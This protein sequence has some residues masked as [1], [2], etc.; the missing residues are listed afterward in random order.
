MRATAWSLFAG[1]LCA[2]L[3]AQMSGTYVIDAA[4]SGTSFRSFTE[5]VNALFVNGVSGACDMLVMP[6]TYTESV[7]I[8]PI[9]GASPQNRILFRAAQGPGTVSLAGGA[10]DTIAMVGVAFL[11][12]QS[13]IFDGIDFTGASGHAISATT[14]CEDIEIRDCT[15]TGNHRSNAPGEWRHALIVSE[16]SG[17]E[18][19]WR[20]HHNRMQIPARTNRGT[21]GIYLSNGGGW[22]FSDNEV[23]LNGCDYGLWLINN[24]RRLDTVWNNLF[25]GSLATAGGTYANNVC[26][27]RADISNYENDFVHN[28]FVVNI[29]GNGCCIATGGY[30]SGTQTVQN[31]IFGNIFQLTGAGAAIVTDA[32]APFLADGN[33]FWA[34]GGEIGRLGANNPGPTSLAAWQAAS[35]RDAASVQADPLLINITTAPYDLRPTPNSPVAGV[36]VNTPTYVT[37]DHQNRLRD[38]TPDAGAYELSGFAVYGTGC[39]GT[40]GAVPAMGS[41]GTVALGSNNF[42]ITLSNGLP[43]ALAVLLGGGSRTQST[44]GA[45][46]F[47]LGGNCFLNASPDATN[48]VFTDPNGAA[49]APLNI[50]NNPGLL[51]NSIFFQWAVLD[52]GSGSAYGIATTAGGALQL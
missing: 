49:P 32:T 17:S 18:V 41:S 45:L 39:A 46:P 36:A 43:N 51:G 48:V 52:P 34:P 44:F 12:T 15:F 47:A 7:L 3:P 33:L 21:Y 35:G 9:A 42:A 37:T 26:V 2:A 10:G 16:N 25:Y 19:G 5:A 11:R 50:P 31:R 27:I 14:F 22:D 29:P 1:C 4:G 20:V 38:T 40:G 30:G 24:N 6:G 8:P 28:T 23:D 13:L